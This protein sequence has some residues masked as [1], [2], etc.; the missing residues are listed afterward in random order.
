MNVYCP[1]CESPNVETAT[2]CKRCSH[3]LAAKQTWSM[4]W[5]TP[6]AQI[7]PR[8]VVKLWLMWSVYVFIAG[9]ILSVVGFI[10]WAGMR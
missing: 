4:L 1:K 9:G 8:D 2:E 6:L 5:D 7:T 3:Q 10:A